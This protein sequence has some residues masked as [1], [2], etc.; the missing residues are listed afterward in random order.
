MCSSQWLHGLELRKIIDESA[1]V[2]R[3]ATF[4]GGPYLAV[5]FLTDPVLGRCYTMA[6]LSL[7]FSQ[8]STCFGTGT[9]MTTHRCADWRKV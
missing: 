6:A 5:A 7:G 4:L 3:V 1:F 2:S 9:H 8:Q